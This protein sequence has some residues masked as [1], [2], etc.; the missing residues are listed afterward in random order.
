MK[1]YAIQARPRSVIRLSIGT[2]CLLVILVFAAGVWISAP[3]VRAQGED[4]YDSE[5]AKAN[6]LLRRRR[7][8]DALKSYKRANDMRDKKSAE[9]LL[10][11]AQAYFGLE[12]YKNVVESCEKVI[13]VAPGDVQSLA[14]AYNYEGIA[15]QTQANV[16]DQKKLADAEAAF[17]KGL[18]LSVELPILR[19]NLGFTLLELG[20]DA[21]GIVELKKYVEAQ[22][23][24][25]KAESAARLIE[26]PRR[27]REAY[28]PDFSLTTADGE[29]VSLDDLHGKV[30]LLDFWG[31]WC[32]PCVAS[33]PALRDLQKRFAKEPQFKMISVSSDGDELKW[34]G[35]I[36]KNQMVWTQY[37]DRDH[38]IQRAFGVHEF[39]FYILI[40]AEGIVRYHQPTSEWEHTGDLPDAI[41]KYL[42]LAAKGPSE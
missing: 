7:F 25:S 3:I 35:F 4:T 19:Y 29:F 39:P 27:A 10:G 40:D 30:L 34:R 37:L 12:A 28:A 13:E 15:L 11:M 9:C 38:H 26:N 24:G 6:D 31:T 16:K 5:V 22:P 21:E 33:V 42:K 41:K 2:T 14:Q 18:A 32:P 36:D 1:P 23:N 20:R 17:R 8:E